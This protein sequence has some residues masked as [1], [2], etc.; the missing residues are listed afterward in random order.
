MLLI[1]GGGSR[2]A[3]HGGTGGAVQTAAGGPRIEGAGAIEE[4]W[5]MAMVAGYEARARGIREAVV[6]GQRRGRHNVRQI[7]RLLRL[8]G[9]AR[10]DLRRLLGHTAEALAQRVTD[11][12]AG[13][14]VARVL[15]DLVIVLVVQRCLA[16]PEALLAQLVGVAPLTAITKPCEVFLVANRAD[17]R[18]HNGLHGGQPVH[19]RQPD[20]A[21]RTRLGHQ[22]CHEVVHRH[23]ILSRKYLLL[24]PLLVVECG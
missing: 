20:E 16:V 11:L 3:G 8:V 12:F 6:R 9:E 19:Q 10:K 2:H 17:S 24:E 5:R 1:V 23:L 7:E 18:M 22:R 14:L 21:G 13:R 15:L 4:A